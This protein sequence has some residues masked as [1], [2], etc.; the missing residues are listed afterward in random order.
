MRL[1]SCHI[2]GFGKFSNQKINLADNIVMIKADNGWGKTTLAHFI[3]SM[4][5][6]L[7]G[8]KKR[9]IAEN[10]RTKYMPWQG[11]AFG[12]SLV[13]SVGEKQYRIERTFGKT[14]SADTVRLYY[15]NNAPPCQ[16][17]YLVR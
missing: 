10:Y 13:F 4:F 16:G 7:D 15:A 12:G 17:I 1:I 5:Y 6:G 9:S 8:A 11:G 2:S 14:P 3:E